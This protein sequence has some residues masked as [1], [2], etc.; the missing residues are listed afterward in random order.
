[1]SEFAKSR[2]EALK[3]CGPEFQGE[4]YSLD[5]Q[6]TFDNAKRSLE[7]K[8]GTLKKMTGGVDKEFAKVGEA[9][10]NGGASACSQVEAALSG[11]WKGELQ[12]PSAAVKPTET[13]KASANPSPEK[14]PF[15]YSGA[16]TDRRVADALKAAGV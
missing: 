1:M 4:G 14:K 12:L 9:L 6:G 5:T 7:A 16:A 11:A 2:A 13:A 3:T 10:R 8:M 15:A